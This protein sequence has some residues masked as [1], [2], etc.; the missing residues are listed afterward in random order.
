MF[1]LRWELSILEPRKSQV[2]QNANGRPSVLKQPAPCLSPPN[3]PLPSLRSA[4]HG[5]R[6]EPKKQLLLLTKNC[7][8]LLRYLLRSFSNFAF[9]LMLR[10][11]G[12]KLLKVYRKAECRAQFCPCKP[13]KIILIPITWLP[14]QGALPPTSLFLTVQTDLPPESSLL[15]APT[16]CPVVQLWNGWR[17]RREE[18]WIQTLSPSR[19][20]VRPDMPFNLSGL[21]VPSLLPLHKFTHEV[22]LKSDNAH[23]RAYSRTK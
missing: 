14:Y 9:P 4:L 20:C 11:Y 12:K 10:G 23:Q 18:S 5:V 15:Q 3:P 13:S 8:Y 2:K 17:D 7:R 1:S 22:R 19:S 6:C 16:V 21:H